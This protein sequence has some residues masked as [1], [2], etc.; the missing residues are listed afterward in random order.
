M[1]L[2]CRAFRPG[3]PFA[4]LKVC[5]P[6]GSQQIPT[7]RPFPLPQLPLRFFCAAV[8]SGFSPWVSFRFAQ[9]M[10]ACGSQQI[11]TVRPF[12][13]PQLPLR[14]L[15]RCPVVVLRAVARTTLLSAFNSPLS[16]V[17]RQ[18][19]SV[20]RYC[21]VEDLSWSPR[22]RRLMRAERA[23]GARAVTPYSPLA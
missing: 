16:S 15:C 10:F 19:S 11:Q 6:D 18:L 22:G 12:P 20:A 5:S 4:S 1:P 9:G 17:A 23:F 3:Y 21:F 2:S 13:L 14:F 7:V 8:L